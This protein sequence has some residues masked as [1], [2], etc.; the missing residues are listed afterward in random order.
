MLVF[1]YGASYVVACAP[2]DGALGATAMTDGGAVADAS[3]FEPEGGRSDLRLANIDMRPMRCRNGLWDPGECGV[4]C[5]GE[6]CG[7]CSTPVQSKSCGG[8]Q[9][10]A[11]YCADPTA[12]CGVGEGS[13]HSSNECQSMLACSAELS[14]FYGLPESVGVCVLREPVLPLRSLQTIAGD[15]FIGLADGPAEQAEFDAPTQLVVTPAGE[16]YVADRGNEVTRKIAPD[17]IVTTIAQ[18][19]VGV[20]MAP[21]GTVYVA[22]ELT[23]SVYRMNAEG[24]AVWIAGAGVAGHRDGPAA[25]AL[26]D[27]P[28]GLAALNDGTVYVSDKYNFRIRRI[29]P[30]G[31]VSTLA[32]GATSEFVDGPGDAARFNYPEGLALDPAGNLYVG[33]KYNHAVRKV[34][35]SG[36]VTTIAGNGV[37]ASIDGPPGAVQLSHPLQI[38][39]DPWGTLYVAEYGAS[40]IRAIPLGGGDS[41]TIV[42]DFGFDDGPIESAHVASAAGIYAAADGRVYVGD[43]GSNR[44]RVLTR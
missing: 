9:G 36:L 8:A 39:L 25:E 3:A 27:H 40:R 6:G 2:V 15:G 41:Y 14:V 35:P 16:I 29:D 30:N 20:G 11:D 34:T 19:G 13:C 43:S 4:D 42:K 18:G 26:F 10:G 32:G 28:F 44:I 24:Q 1:A 17:G 12:R 21:N 5:G 31:T 38:S 22:S 33:D 23:H 7:P 37:A